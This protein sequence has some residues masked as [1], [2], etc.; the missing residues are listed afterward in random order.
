VT[1]ESEDRTTLNERLLDMLVYAPTGL[2]VSAIEEFPRLAALGRRQ[3][4]KRI[5]SARVVGEYAVRSGRSQ[6]KRRTEDLGRP[7]AGSSGRIG[8]PSG[9]RSDN[10]SFGPNGTM[11]DPIE[12]TGHPAP[13]EAK[14]SDIGHLPDVSALAIPGFATLSASQVVQRLD[15][16]SRTELVATRA[17]EAGTRGRRTILG[18][19][20]Q[21]LDER[22]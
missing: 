7:N 4:G 18:R 11:S 19:V 14:R 6:I 21:L 3:L 13:D 2:V 17:Y 20:D 15:G 10:R 22:A 1:G 9:Q 12:P 8:R 5:S 16:L